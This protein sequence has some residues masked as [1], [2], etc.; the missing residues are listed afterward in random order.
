VPAPLQTSA[1]NRKSAA[2]HLLLVIAVSALSLAPTCGK[3]KPP[4]PPIERIP[5]RT[6]ELSGLQRGNQIIL[7]WPAPRRNANEGSV[8]SIRRVDVYRVAEKPNAP[9]P[10]TEDEFAA[11][12]TLVGSVTYDEIK[13]GGANLTYVDTLELSG[14]PGRLRYAVRYVNASG[15]RA[16]F[17]NFFRMEPSAKVAEPPTIVTTGKEKSETALTITWEAPKRN[18]DGSTPVNLLG[19]NIY[20]TTGSQPEAGQKPLNQ[21]PIT[22]T[23]YPDKTFKFGEKYEYVVRSISL[24]TEARPVESLDSN[25]FPL[26]QEDTYPPSAPTL[27]P[28]GGAPGRLALFWSASPELDVAGYLLYRST[29]PNLPKPWTLLTPAVYTKTTFTDQNVETGKTYYYYVIAVD[30]AGNKSE[31]SE[32]LSETVP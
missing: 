19:Y 15:Q 11:R 5:Q 12:S 14:E 17:S 9:L 25:A 31:P 32:V 1:S 20:R 4:L 18:I 7:S 10:M 6:E 22:G 27:A 13:K 29:D 16:A 8:Q 24:G 26:S 28:P 30:N 21:E 23:Q 2:R 3:R